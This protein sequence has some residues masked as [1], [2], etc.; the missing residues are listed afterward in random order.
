MAKG[1]TDAQGR[2]YYNGYNRD[3]ANLIITARENGAKSI[4][5]GD[6][7]TVIEVVWENTSAEDD[8]WSNPDGCHWCGDP[9]ES[10]GPGVTHPFIAKPERPRNEN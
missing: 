9:K 10:H 6:T 5:I 4:K 1:L 8:Y 2:E 3:M 7:D